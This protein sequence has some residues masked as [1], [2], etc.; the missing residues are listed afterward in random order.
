M[1]V[2][3]VAALEEPD[4]VEPE[5]EEEA[6]ELE[7]AR[8]AGAE[9]DEEAEEDPDEDPVE[10]E[11][12]E[13][14]S[15]E[16]ANDEET[17]MEP[18][19]VLK[20]GQVQEVDESEETEDEEDDE[21][22]SEVD[23]EYE[24]VETNIVAEDGTRGLVHG[25]ATDDMN[26]KIEGEHVKYVDKNKDD[27]ANILSNGDDAAGSRNV[28]M[29]NS[30]LAGGL[31]LLVDELPKNC[32]EGD[33]A[34]IFPE[35]GEIKSI[36]IIRNSST[37]K[38]KD[39]AFVC[40]ASI[41]A[42]DKALTECKKGIEVKET[43]VRVS[44]CQDNN[45]LFLG[46]ICKSWTEDQVLTALKNIG[47]QECKLRMP[48]NYKGTNRGFGFL[49][50]DSHYYARAAFRQL[51]KS[52]A[53]FGIDRSVTV[54]FYRNPTKPSDDLMEAKRV[55]LEHVPPSWNEEK[56]KE[57]C[58]EYGKI[59]NVDLFQ[60]ST[61][62]KSETFSFVE[63][64]S[65]N[66]ALACVEGINNAKIVD[67]SIK[68]S[69]CLARPKNG[70]ISGSAMTSKKKN[71]HREKAK[72]V[73]VKKNAPSKL[74]KDN[75]R[76]IT[77]QDAAEVQQT[78]QPSEGERKLGKNKNASVNQRASKK[79]RNKCHADGSNLTYENAAVLQTP[80][81]SKGKR[82]S[83]K[84]VNGYTNKRPLKKAHNS[85]TVR[86][87]NGTRC[88]GQPAGPQYSR[89][90]HSLGESSRS[91][92]Y[93]SDL[94]PHAGY[95]SLANQVHSAQAYDQLRIGR[96]DIHPRDV[97]PYARETAPSRA[98]YSDYTSHT[99]YQTEYEYIY[100]PQPTSGSYYPGR[101]PFITR[102]GDY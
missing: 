16:E 29:Q 22:P 39:I 77:S 19:V 88:A 47:I 31:E 87:P 65:S 43:K 10:E 6:V 86:R 51:I 14:D 80:N 54:S 55:Y 78:S 24:E 4:A 99:R 5:N 81:P 82:K 94:E 102:R 1:V 15:R 40:F 56:I 28:D 13:E 45:T 41:E 21:E 42:A 70:A 30:E 27:D 33:I 23:D 100:P 61:N 44:G 83:G 7:K 74:L 36:R 72:E 76:K 69:A 35:S 52:D 84:D 49:K 11:K 46:N 26:E 53:I 48:A 101:G 60:I 34:M 98:T 97:H 73:G 90:H 38:S 66:S 59:V 25:S 32:V 71:D 96:Y 57:C 50:F 58:E 64:S 62:M 20:P 8:A 79:A 92:A 95:I 12:D 3:A 67:G 18:L 37:E 9:P 93:A 91:K 89:S 68:L 17:V 85:R 75:K 2:G 63:F